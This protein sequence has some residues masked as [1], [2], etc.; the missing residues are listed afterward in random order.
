MEVLL[1]IQ[2]ILICAL[3]FI[4]VVLL[5]RPGKIKKA[6]LDYTDTIKKL[7]A[8]SEQTVATTNAVLN[9]IAVLDSINK[10]KG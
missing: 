6:E 5:R 3:L 9:L 10:R 8:L 7:H 1:I 2:L 4:I